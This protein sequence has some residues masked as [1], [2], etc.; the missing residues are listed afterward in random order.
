GGIV[1]LLEEKKAK[2]WVYVEIPGVSHHYTPYKA[3]Y[4][5][6]QAAF[7][8]FTVSQNEL[9][10]GLNAVK[11]HYA[12]VSAVYGY[13]VNVPDDVYSLLVRGW[14]NSH[15]PGEILPITTE[16]TATYP[17]SAIAWYFHGQVYQLSDNLD[18]ARACFQK[19]VALEQARMLPDSE[20]LNPMLERLKD[21]AK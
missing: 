20:W 11:K 6:L 17:W 21:I 4:E 2:G 15:D 19:A 7:P 5:G 13:S 10:Q 3:L 8:G 18:K 9:N 1:P 14:F 16:W 12:N